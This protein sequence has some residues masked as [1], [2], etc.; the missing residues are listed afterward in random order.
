MIIIRKYHSATEQTTIG[1]LQ[2]TPQK[3]LFNSPD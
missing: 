3:L 1:Q 2:F